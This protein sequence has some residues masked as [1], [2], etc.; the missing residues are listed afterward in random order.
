L[1]LETDGKD[2]RKTQSV[3]L[4]RS[5]WGALVLVLLVSIFSLW[6]SWESLFEVWRQRDAYSHGYIIAIVCLY[7]LFRLK[8]CLIA[9]V[10]AP[11]LTGLLLLA[12]L[13]FLWLI[14]RLAGTQ[15]GELL[16]LPIIVWA[17]Y[18]SIVG[19]RIA[20]H[21]V[22]PLFFLYF[23]IPIW[24]SGNYFLQWLTVLAVERMVKA[25]GFLAY[26]EANNVFLPMGTFVIADGCS[27]LNYFIVA[28][29]I[30]ML[31]S[32]LYL[33]SYYH[34][35]ILVLVGM[36]LGLIMN[37]LR[38]FIIIYAGYKTDMQHYLVTVD[39]TNFGWVLFGITLVPLLF[40]ARRLEFINE[41]AAKA[42]HAVDQHVTST[43]LKKQ[44]AI[45]IP[46]IAMASFMIILSAL[47][48][49]YRLR[50][51]SEPPVQICLPLASKTWASVPEIQPD[52][53]PVFVGPKEELHAT[54]SNGVQT[55]SLYVNVYTD[56]THGAELIGYD[57]HIEGAG[58]WK[59]RDR[60]V[61][62]VVLD[63]KKSLKIRDVLLESDNGNKRIVY[64]W[65]QVGERRLIKD[66]HVKLLQGLLQITDRPYSGIAALSST[67][68]LEDC[69]LAR[70]NLKD[71]ILQQWPSSWRDMSLWAENC[72]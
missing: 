64:Y 72:I 56:Q 15:I 34:K 37:W 50:P 14:M 16:L 9:E 61:G 19:F 24:H 25:A 54:Y 20:A 53:T 71:W 27:G 39:H 8:G 60:R 11:Q 68:E 5:A 26:I 33:Q 41:R 70:E 36:S 29:A 46:V 21:V 23:A 67:C 62:E 30:S 57:N 49:D 6:P 40:V 45:Y 18:F 10:P 31:Y 32:Y 2:T 48:A 44:S 59:L 1:A 43:V 52:W 66:L 35:V 47:L 69:M 22:F 17:A 13:L 58:K 55:V 12:A 42:K 51:M 38:V 3:A 65:Y 28:V 7:L 63:S 4:M